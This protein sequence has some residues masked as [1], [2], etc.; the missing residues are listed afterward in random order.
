MKKWILAVALL[1]TS[2]ALAHELMHEELC[3]GF[4]PENDLNIPVGAVSTFGGGIA[5]GIDQ[6]EFNAVLDRIQELYG[7]EIAKQGATLAINRLWDNGTVNASANR[8]GNTWQI[9]M[10]GGLARHKSI[11]SDGFALV[12]CH[13]IGHHIGGAPKI[14]RFLGKATWASNEGGSDYFATLKCLRRYFEFDDNEKIISEMQ[15]EPF[16]VR[17]CEQEYT[18]RLEQLFCIRGAHAGLSVSGLFNSLRKSTTP[19]SFSTP[20]PK[21][22]RKTDHKHPDSQCRLDTYFAGALCKVPVQEALSD[23]DYKAGSCFDSRRHNPRSLRPRCW[24]KPEG[25]GFVSDDFET[26]IV[27]DAGTLY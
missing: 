25:R 26:G 7:P 13:E 11:T 3:E 20:D 15:L 23:R 14:K 9:N 5:G 17:A 22:V 18:S 1:L 27:E 24:F 4:I 16:A 2:G 21:Q 10:Y 8:F 12:A 6:Q 19:L